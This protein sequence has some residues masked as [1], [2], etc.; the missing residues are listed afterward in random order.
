MSSNEDYEYLGDLPDV[1]GPAANSGRAPARGEPSASAAAALGEG[2]GEAR[3]EVRELRNQVQDVLDRLTEST[4]DQKHLHAQLLQLGEV[5]KALAEAQQ[6]QGPAEDEEPPRP[7]DW[8][9]VPV[10]ER[11]SWMEGR[12]RWVRDV[13]FTNYDDAHTRLR[14]CWPLHTTLLNDMSLLEWIYDDGFGES[15]R[16]ISAESF[17][18]TV[19]TMLE[20][21]ERLTRSCPQPDSDQMHP[22]PLPPRDDAAQVALMRRQLALQQALEYY[23]QG[24]EVQEALK[25]LGA[26]ATQADHDRTAQRVQELGESMRSA[27][28]AAGATRQEWEAFRDQARLQLD[29][30]T[31]VLASR[32]EQPKS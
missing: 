15:R 19:E 5:V 9:Q 18:R 4:N 17:R 14:P 16:L 12:A 27:I 3:A 8:A 1:G 25:A 6:Q 29:Q 24:G 13:L 10:D 26:Q 11:D 22:V 23:L 30:R 7:M 2:L 28:R 20:R 21:A 32:G 31:K